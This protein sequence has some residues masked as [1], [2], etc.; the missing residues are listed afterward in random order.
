MRVAIIG[1]RSVTLEMENDILRYL[2]RSTHEIVSGGATGADEIAQRIA[3]Q[4]GI[5]M[6]IFQPNYQKFQRRA[7]LE[8][9][10]DI[11]RYADYVLALWDGTSKGTAHAINTCIR[12][13]TP[14]RVLLCRDGKLAETLFGPDAKLL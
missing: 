8:R 2:P 7:P 9:N 4:L 12:E 11:V 6:K 1:S 3:Q 14:V 10:V 5:P 13:Y